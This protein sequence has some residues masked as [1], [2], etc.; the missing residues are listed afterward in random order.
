MSLITTKQ[1][2]LRRKNIRYITKTH[3]TFDHPTPVECPK[4]HGPGIINVGEVSL[5]VN[6]I[7]FLLDV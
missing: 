4:G 1:I 5:F 6:F 7:Y 2:V 3:T